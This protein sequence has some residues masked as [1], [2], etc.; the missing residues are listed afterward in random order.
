[1]CVSLRLWLPRASVPA[2]ADLGAGGCGTSVMRASRAA[3]IVA[4]APTCEATPLL[5][6]HT[7]SKLR[8]HA[9]TPACCVLCGVALMLAGGIADCFLLPADRR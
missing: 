4:L 7:A 2:H 5:A 1:M 6:V 8:A 3:T 9:L